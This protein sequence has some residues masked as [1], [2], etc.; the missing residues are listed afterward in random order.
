MRLKAAL[1][2][3]VLFCVGASYGV[4]ADNDSTTSPFSVYP[5]E[6]PEEYAEELKGYRTNWTRV[7]GFEHSGLHWQQFIAIFVNK[8]ADVYKNNY[9]E[10]LRYYQD[11][12]E[13]EDEEEVEEPAFKAYSPG[14]IILKENYSS[15]KGI[16][17][18]AISVT[19]MI[20]HEPG[21]DSENGDWEY[22]QFATNGDLILVGN[23]QDET[24]KQVCANCHINIADR[25]YIFANFFAK[26]SEE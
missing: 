22:V 14:T 16:P 11:Y 20:K 23:A 24:I 26:A 21:Y 4:F 7:S 12:D 8:D 1:V 2:S 9:R 13:D 5:F 25:D 3:T 6:I 19:M 10:Y 17:H 15:D 18:S